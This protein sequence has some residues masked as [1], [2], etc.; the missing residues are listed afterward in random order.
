MSNACEKVLTDMKEFIENY[1]DCSEC[2]LWDICEN[3]EE[4]GLTQFLCKEEDEKFISII[5][6]CGGDDK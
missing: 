1:C 4:K 2:P 5:K 3:A 6:E